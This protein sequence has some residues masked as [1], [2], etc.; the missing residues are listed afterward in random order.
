MRGVDALR[1][2]LREIE[3]GSAGD[4]RGHHE[5]YS[6]YD[7][8]PATHV[9]GASA[10]GALQADAQR[11]LWLLHF[12]SFFPFF[13]LATCAIWSCAAIFFQLIV[14]RLK[15]DAENFRGASLVVVGRFQSFENQQ[16]LS[17]A[18]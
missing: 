13:L 9:I 6:Q 14:Q 16:A 11:Y 12:L 1:Q 5:G 3:I 17:F 15:A 18:Y 7:L 10:F 4:E 2:N 8:G